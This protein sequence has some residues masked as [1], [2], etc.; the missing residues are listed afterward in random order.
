MEDQIMKEMSAAE[1]KTDEIFSENLKNQ[2]F[3]IRRK[4]CKQNLALYK[5]VMG[6]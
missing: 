3:H 1:I 4:T 2:F 5:N 6:D